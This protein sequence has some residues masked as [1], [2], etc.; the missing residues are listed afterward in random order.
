MTEISRLCDVVHGYGR[1]RTDV[2]G[3]IAI[4]KG[5]A[6]YPGIDTSVEPEQTPAAI[7]NSVFVVD[8]FVQPRAVKTNVFDTDFLEVLIFA[9]GPVIRVVDIDVQRFIE[10]NPIALYFGYAVLFAHLDTI[11]QH[12]GPDGF[13]R[14][15][16]EKFCDGCG[17]V[18]I[19]RNP[20]AG[21]ESGGIGYCDIEGFSIG[22]F[23]NGRQGSIAC[24]AGLENEH[25]GRCPQLFGIE[26]R[27]VV[28]LADDRASTSTTASPEDDIA[29][30]DV[31]GL[32]VVCIGVDEK[33]ARRKEDDA[34]VVLLGCGNGAYNSCLVGEAIVGDGTMSC[35]VEY[36][37]LDTGNGLV[38]VVIARV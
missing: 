11:G 31:D 35:D 16:R 33:F 17:A 8:K 12:G 4:D 21:K 9:H 7:V 29:V 30:A 28:H 20:L 2:K 32:V 24:V 14:V 23:R 6:P 38:K 13:C 37:A 15:G 36:V 34:A 25:I 22:T 3:A 5:C 19:E 26:R 10:A 1:T 27:H 18:H